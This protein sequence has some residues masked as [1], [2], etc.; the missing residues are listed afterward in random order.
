L[1]TAFLQGEIAEIFLLAVENEAV[2]HESA[3]LGI[4]FSFTFSGMLGAAE[5]P[6][7]A[8][9]GGNAEE[10]PLCFRDGLDDEF[11]G[12][13]FGPPLIV[14]DGDDFLIGRHIVRWQEDGATG[15]AGFESVVRGLELTNLPATTS[16]RSVA[17]SSGWR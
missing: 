13:G 4:R 10:S 16:R 3:E 17:R 14:G 8:F 1:Q 2:D 12:V 11:V 9:E 5:G 6:D 7:Y 15:E